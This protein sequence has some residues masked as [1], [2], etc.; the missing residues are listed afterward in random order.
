MRAYLEARELVEDFGEAVVEVLLRELDLAHVERADTAN[1]EVLV[2]HRRR[3][4]LGHRQNHIHEVF[5]GR[6]GAAASRHT[7]DDKNLRPPRKSTDPRLP[8]T[9]YPMDLKLYV[10]IVESERRQRGGA[11]Q[12]SGNKGKAEA[13]GVRGCEER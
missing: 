1:L 3:L 11:A 5:R 10:T 7:Q 12:T 6:H 13:H 8:T 2:H 9:T 4:A